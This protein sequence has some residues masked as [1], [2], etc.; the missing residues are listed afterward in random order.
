MR[1]LGQGRMKAVQIALA[2]LLAAFAYGCSAARADEYYGAGGSAAIYIAWTDAGGKLTGQTIAVRVNPDDQT[3][4]QTVHAAL[5]G[6]R[7]GDEVTFT[8]GGLGTVTGHIRQGALSVIVAPQYGGGLPFE[9]TLAKG[10][11]ASFEAAVQRLEDGV[12]AR[13]RAHDNAVA[14][15]PVKLGVY[16]QTGPLGVYVTKIRDGGLAAKAGVQVGDRIAS[17]KGST[18]RTLGDFMN[19]MADIAPGDT[20]TIGVQR[21]MAS[22]ELQIVSYK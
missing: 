17:I 13:Q 18:I 11:Y 14:D 12:V 1:T 9:M 3:R 6:V 4:L 20:F 7:D 16:L 22:V 10:S 21:G 15:P 5:V 2:A 19:A 8:S